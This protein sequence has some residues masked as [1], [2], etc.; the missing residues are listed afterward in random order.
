M[1]E[2][3]Y[4]GLPDGYYCDIISGN[5][6]NGS[7]TGTEVWVHNG[8]ATISITGGHDDPIVAFHTG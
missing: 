6:E 2:H 8:Y 3:L 7:C 1:Q 4:T 5:L